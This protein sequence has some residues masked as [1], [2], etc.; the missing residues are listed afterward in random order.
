MVAPLRFMRNFSV[1][2]FNSITETP[3]P[4]K[5]KEGLLSSLDFPPSL[6]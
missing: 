6:M 4:V 1:Y 3:P 2:N 5:Q